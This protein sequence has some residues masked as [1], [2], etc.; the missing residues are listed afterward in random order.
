MSTQ[1]TETCASCGCEFTLPIAFQAALRRNGN[2][3]YCPSGHGQS[4]TGEVETLKK[5]V[6][7]LTDQ[8]A[9]MTTYRDNAKKRLD[10]CLSEAAKPVYLCIVAGCEERRGTKH[11]MR[12]HLR[13]MHGFAPHAVRALPA[14]AGP[15][16]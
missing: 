9:Q 2:T 15:S 13:T 14:D 5:Q 11:A 6:A 8:L 4:Y 3:F 10:Y 16:S 7:G 12:R 1:A